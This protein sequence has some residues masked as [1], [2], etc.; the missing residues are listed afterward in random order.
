MLHDPSQKKTTPFQLF[1]REGTRN[2]SMRY[3]FGGRQYKKTLG[4]ADYDQAMQHAYK[5][6]HEQSFR[7]KQGC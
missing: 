1:Q 4:T 3:S 6:W 5:I 7:V 2:W